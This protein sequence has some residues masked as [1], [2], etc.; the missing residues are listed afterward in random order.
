M[1]G[2]IGS[3][4]TAA[5]PANNDG[6]DGGSHGGNDDKKGIQNARSL[7]EPPEP[8]APPVKDDCERGDYYNFRS[9]GGSDGTQHSL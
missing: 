7:P 6:P 5:G 2:D 8:P 9:K 1:C 4:S 3:F